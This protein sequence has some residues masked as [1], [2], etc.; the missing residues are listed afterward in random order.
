ML[1]VEQGLPPDV[2]ELTVSGLYARH[3]EWAVRKRRSLARGGWS[4]DCEDDRLSRDPKRLPHLVEMAGDLAAR[5]GW[6]ADTFACSDTGLVKPD[7]VI[8]KRQSGRGAGNLLVCEL[9]R[10][11]A[12]KQAIAADLVKLAGYRE[13]IGYEHAFLILL[14]DAREDCVV[15]RASTSLQEIAW[16]VQHLDE[17]AAVRR[18]KRGY[19]KAAL[20]QRSLLAA[21]GPRPALA[22]AESLSALNALDTMGMWPA[23]RDAISEQSVQQVR[24]RWARVQ[25]RAKQAWSR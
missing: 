12:S 24:R 2:S 7:V 4:V 9:R 17:A 10:I 19:A 13:Y 5:L 18:W 8:H 15:H 1:E 16:Y 25:H 3:L 23:P 11:D 14:G 21:E 20:R 22:V 6:P